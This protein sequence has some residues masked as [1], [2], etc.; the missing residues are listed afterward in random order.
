MPTPGRTTVASKACDACRTRKVKCDLTPGVGD[1][2]RCRRCSR[3][4]LACT[5]DR[6]S[7][8]RGPRRRV[9]GASVINVKVRRPITA[10][11]PTISITNTLTPDHVDTPSSTS[12]HI[13]PTDGLCARPLVRLIVEDYLERV[14]PLVPVVHRPSFC[15]A[16]AADH[17]IDNPVFA[18]LLLAICAVTVGLLPSRYESC[19]CTW[20]SPGPPLRFT[21]R[22]AMMNYCYDGV[23]RRRGPRYFDEIDFAK[24]AISYLLSITFFQIGDQNRARMME[25]EAMQLGRLLQ[26]HKIQEYA[27]LS[28]IEAQLRRKGFWL[29][30]Y[31]YVHGEL[32]NFRKERLCFLD[33]GQL[34]A[35]DLEALLPLDIDDEQIVADG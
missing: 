29:L 25:V 33:A 20:S 8:L 13:Y 12:Q 18:S 31:A 24:L 1:G 17:D 30:F 32:Q 21:S 34:A 22:E 35:L 11:T 9:T 23:L 27:G 10:V 26:V 5:F 16:L 15:A 2:E 6:P 4:D 14:Y 3:L 7:G 28:C 19:Y